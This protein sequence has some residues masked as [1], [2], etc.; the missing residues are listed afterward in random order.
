MPKMSVNTY[1][2]LQE[3]IMSVLYDNYPQPVSALVVAEAM[4][5]DPELIRRLLKE[6]EGKKFVQIVKNGKGGEFTTW[7]RWKLTPQIQQRYS[8]L[9]R[10]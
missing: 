1:Q 8:Q 5:R 4:I 10:D 2:K 9:S 6:L 3:Q 7:Q